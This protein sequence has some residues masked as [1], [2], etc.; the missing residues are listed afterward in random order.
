MPYCHCEAVEHHFDTPFVES[1]FARYKRGEYPAAT[2]ILVDALKEFDLSGT[3]L[4]DVGAGFGALMWELFPQGVISATVI[5][6]APAYLAIAESEAK[7]R[8][9]HE[10]VR[11]LDGD[12]VEFASEVPAADIVTLDRVICCYP[13]MERLVSASTAR[14]ERWLAA[15]FPRDLWYSRLD[16]A[17]TNLKRRRSGDPFRTFVYDEHHIDRQITRADFRRTFDRKTWMW[18]VSIYERT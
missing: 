13:D 15:S 17:Y 18:R 9:L 7:R 5:E 4:L 12:F 14:C 11:F 2:R 1:R 3:T 10:S 16:A 8:G 6:S